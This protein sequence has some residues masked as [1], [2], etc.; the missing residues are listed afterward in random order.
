MGDTTGRG[1][2]LHLCLSLLGLCLSFLGFGILRHHRSGDYQYHKRHS[3][4]RLVLRSGLYPAVD[5]LYEGTSVL[6][7]AL[8]GKSRL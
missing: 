8:I 4:D 6:V 2:L 7:L 3:G 1:G 5:L